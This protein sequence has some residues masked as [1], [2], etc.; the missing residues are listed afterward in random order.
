MSTRPPRCKDH[1]L[2]QSVL[3]LEWLAEWCAAHES[4]ETTITQGMIDTALKQKSLETNSSTS[5]QALIFNAQLLWARQRAAHEVLARAEA[6]ADQLD[7][8][9]QE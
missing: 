1:L 4:P 2:P 8:E 9:V 3:E 7:A 6:C 5:A